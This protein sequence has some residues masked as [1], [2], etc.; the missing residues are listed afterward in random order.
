MTEN[1]KKQLAE[2]FD[3]GELP[4]KAK[5]MEVGEATYARRLHALDRALRQQP[6]VVVPSGFV[7]MV[8]NR[9]PAADAA[10]RRVLGVRDVMLPLLLLAALAMSFFFADFLGTASLAKTMSDGLNALTGESSVQIG[11]IA[12][13]GLGILFVSWFIVSSFFGIRSRRVTRS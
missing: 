1:K 3:K 5:P 6:E 2:A 8:M 4:D 12:L 9:L 13:T 11:F 10:M 7:R